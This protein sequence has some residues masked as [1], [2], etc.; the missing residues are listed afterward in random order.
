MTMISIEGGETIDA[1]P[2]NTALE[3][4]PLGFTAA[5]AA[6]RTYVNKMMPA[7]MA[8][9]GNRWR[10]T[11]QGPFAFDSMWLGPAV[12]SGKAWDFSAATAVTWDTGSA[13]KTVTDDGEYLSDVITFEHDPSKALLCAIE[14]PIGAVLPV[15][16]NLPASR[17]SAFWFAGAEGNDTTKSAGYTPEAGIQYLIRKLEAGRV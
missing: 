17:F 13:S 16:Y 10:I 14:A 9:S 3:L 2:W 12:T 7:A 1:T 11:A 15:I 5:L 8:H 6:V 4:T